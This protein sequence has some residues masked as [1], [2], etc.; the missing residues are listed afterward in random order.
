M[1]ADREAEQAAVVETERRAETRRA[2]QNRLDDL[3]ARLGQA[4][5]RVADELTLA[6]AAEKERRE[7]ESRSEQA[8]LDEE[9]E[10]LRRNDP[11]VTITALEQ[12]FADNEAP[13]APIDCE[14]ERVTVAMEFPLPEAIVPERKPARTPTGRATLKKRTK[15][16]I[17]TL[18]LQ[19]LGSNVLATVKETFA[20]APGTQI[21]QILVIRRETDGKQANQWVA[22]YVGEFDRGHYESASASRDPAETL[23]SAPEATLRLKGQGQEVFPLDLTKR[24][25]LAAVLDQVASG[26]SA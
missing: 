4:R 21:V 2:E 26:L 8:K 12:A 6:V 19:A 15:T 17:H 1:L 11:A 24:D 23:R 16:E 22:I 20:V 25:D 14:R 10:C 5:T 13:A 9:W 7:A 18:Y 3:W